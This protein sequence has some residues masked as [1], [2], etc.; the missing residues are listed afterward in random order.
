M[1]PSSTFPRT[2]LL[3]HDR[4]ADAALVRGASVFEEEDALPSAKGH[5]AINDGND[6][7]AAGQR[8]PDVTRHVVRALVSVNEV[9]RV[10]RDKMIEECLKVLPGTRVRILH[11]DEARR[12]V[13]DEDGDSALP[14]SGGTD[15]TVDL[16]GDLI[17]PLPLSSQGEVLGGSAHT[18]DRVNR[19]TACP[20]FA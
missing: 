20:P 17:G 11:D 9:R 8:H 1:P 14:D 15:D 6:L 3:S 16:P 7:T 4:N 13:L 5:A 19:I 12:S 10:L 2:Q 18:R